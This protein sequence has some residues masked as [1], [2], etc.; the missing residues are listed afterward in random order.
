MGLRMK[1]YVTCVDNFKFRENFLDLTDSEVLA[2]LQIINAE[3]SGVYTLWSI[4]SPAERDAK[5]ELCVN[6]LVGWKLA[7]MYPER[8][9]G[10]G[11]T[12]TMPLT[13]KI[14]DRVHIHYRDTIRQGTGVLDM[15]TNNVFGM[16]ALTMIQGAPENYMVML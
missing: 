5:R 14:V 6:Y 12:G 3:F 8:T 16:H 2:A 11:S 9:V 15:L 13:M 1:N 7:N 4:L 10:V